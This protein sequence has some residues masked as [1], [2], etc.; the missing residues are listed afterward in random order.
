MA[1][2]RY[3][4]DAERV[5]VSYSNPGG[6]VR[7][8]RFTLTSAVAVPRVV[9]RSG[10]A[11]G[12]DSRGERYDPYFFALSPCALNSKKKLH[13]NNQRHFHPYPNP[14]RVG[15]RLSASVGC[16]TIWRLSFHFVRWCGLRSGTRYLF[17]THLAPSDNRSTK[18]ADGRVA[19]E[20]RL[21]E[22][23]QLGKRRIKDEKPKN[24]KREKMKEKA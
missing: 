11:I 17:H 15:D 21:A 8:A 18:S 16:A 14:R 24:K 19:T 20:A 4:S 13:E 10:A 23:E 9:R 2:S 12:G 1:S 7:H 22:C 5:S 3:P 6:P